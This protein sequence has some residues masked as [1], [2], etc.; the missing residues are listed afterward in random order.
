[1]YDPIDGPDDIQPFNLGG[2]YWIR[3]QDNTTGDI[4]DVPIEGED[5]IHWWTRGVGRCDCVRYRAFQQIRGEYSGVPRNF[6]KL[7]S[8]AECGKTR[9]R[10]LG[11]WDRDGL[12]IFSGE[13]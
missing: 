12:Q 1:M 2:F 3:L 13:E 9:M 10:L 11:I 4:E 6:D 8:P 7:F 5:V